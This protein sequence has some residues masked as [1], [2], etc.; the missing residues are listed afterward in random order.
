MVLLPAAMAGRMRVSTT[1]IAGTG[2]EIRREPLQPCR[3]QRQRVHNRARTAALAPDFQATEGCA[4]LEAAGGVKTHS[5]LTETGLLL[6][7][8]AARQT[9]LSSRDGS[10]RLFASLLL[11]RAD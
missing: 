9:A 3:I 7:G 1:E 2:H 4:W 8:L 11:V 10:A 5:Q 6:L